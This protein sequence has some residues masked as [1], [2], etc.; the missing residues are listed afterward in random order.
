MG[1]KISRA[2][3]TL[4]DEQLLYDKKFHNVFKEYQVTNKKYGPVQ[5]FCNTADESIQPLNF[6]QLPEHSDIR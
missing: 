1:M 2:F 3:I 5:I 6:L 4:P